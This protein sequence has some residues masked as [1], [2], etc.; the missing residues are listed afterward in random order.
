[1]DKIL[2]V[3]IPIYNEEK[4]IHNTI[5]Q[6]DSYLRSNFTGNYEIIA[7]DD[8]STDTT[9]ALLNELLAVFPCLRIVTHPDNI[10]R[11]KGAAVRNGVLHGEGDIIIFTDC[12]LSYGLDV[13]GRIVDFFNSDPTA[14]IVIG[15]R[16]ISGDGYDGYTLPRKIMS[17]CYIK[18]LTVF[19]GLRYTDSQSGIKGFR[20]K[21]AYDVFG[22]CEINRFA[23]DMEVLMIADKLR[24]TI[25]ELD[26]KIL[27]HSENESKV[28]IIKDTF[29]MIRD[30]NRIR[31][32]LKRL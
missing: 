10:N 12:D 16:N 14:D 22:K 4:I 23:F 26:V 28:K 19:A 31:K 1:M 20:R 27:N 11:G 32:R 6:V 9:L 15:S 29:R 3:V 13:I 8:G 17:K 24:Y 25:K 21:A 30:M 2:S 7:S 5:T 18:M